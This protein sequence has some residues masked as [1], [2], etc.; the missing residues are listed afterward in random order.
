MKAVVFAYQDMGI[1]GIRRLLEAGL[2]IPLV[3]SHEDD[4]A[5][6]IWFASVKDLCA[7]LNIPCLCPRNPGQFGWMEQIRSSR[8]DF[9]FSF[10]YQSLLRPSILSLPRL[11]AYNLHYS[12]LPLYRGKCPVNWV[13]ARGETHTGV[14]L[15]AMVERPHA[16]A[17]IAQKEVEISGDDTVMTLFGKL[18][19]A[20]AALLEG[21]LPTMMKGGIRKTPMDLSRGSYFREMTPEDGRIFWDRPAEEI[22]NLIRAVTRPFTGAYGFVGDDMVTFWRAVPDMEVTLEPGRIDTR[23]GTVLMGTGYGCIRILEIEV[24]GRTLEDEGLLKYF[25]GHEGG[26]A[27]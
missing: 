3:F 18:D 27:Q 12:L 1:L 26:L 21:T 5:G 13:L 25:R 14:T 4:P 20:A 7:R 17:V 10:G 22:Y 23:G 16:G 24:N 15:H 2:D 8:P 6:N 11:G 9:I 19:T